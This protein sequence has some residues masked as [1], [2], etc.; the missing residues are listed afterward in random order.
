MTKP[1]LAALMLSVLTLTS[2]CVAPLVAGA[3]AAIAVDEINE[4]EQGGD[5][6]F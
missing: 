5:G 1:I 4:R 2:G 3:G 6:L